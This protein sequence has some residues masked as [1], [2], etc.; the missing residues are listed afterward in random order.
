MQPWLTPSTLVE[1][2]VW[3]TLKKK[4]YFVLNCCTSKPHFISS[5][6]NHV[7]FDDYAHNA[8]KSAHCCVFCQLVL[9]MNLDHCLKIWFIWNIFVLLSHNCALIQFLFE[10]LSSDLLGM[11]FITFASLWKHLFVL[12]KKLLSV[13]HIFFFF[14]FQKGCCSN[15]RF[16]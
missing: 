14:F 13:Q 11:A 15:D 4:K 6:S 5:D 8:L 12:E 16:I 7:K 3:L 1:K 2:K 9:F 10:E